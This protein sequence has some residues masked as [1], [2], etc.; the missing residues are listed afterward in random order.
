MFYC[1]L[2][3]TSCKGLDELLALEESASWL[4]WWGFI[5]H[6]QSDQPREWRLDSIERHRTIMSLVVAWS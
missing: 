1:D 3:S 5:A 2:K 6:L 4:D